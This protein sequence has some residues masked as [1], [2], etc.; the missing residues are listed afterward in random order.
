MRDIAALARAGF[1]PELAR[2]IV[3]A[4]ADALEE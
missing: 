2:K 1:E 3:D 4:E